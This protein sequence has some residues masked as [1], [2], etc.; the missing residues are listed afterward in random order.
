MDL[1]LCIKYIEFMCSH[2]MLQGVPQNCDF[3]DESE[4]KMN[5]FLNW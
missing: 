3:R 2:S 5:H 4:R 1:F